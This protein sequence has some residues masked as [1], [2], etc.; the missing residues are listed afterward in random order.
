M[1]SLAPAQR[2]RVDDP[3]VVGALAVFPLIAEDPPAV[4]YLAFAEAVRRGASITELADP[5]V[6]ALVVTNPLDLPVLLYAGQE[7]LG[8]QQNRIVADSVLVLARSERQVAVN[9]VEHGRWDDERRA[10]PF[11]PA[12]QAAYP[13]LRKQAGQAAV[14]SEVRARAARAGV[15]SETEAVHDLYEH[16]R[17][18]LD[19]IVR[20]VAARP[21]QVGAIAAVA[22]A[23]VVLDRVSRPDVWAALHGPL[24][25]G[26]ALQAHETRARETRARETRAPIDPPPAG[27]IALGAIAPSDASA[28]RESSP[29]VADALAFA[30]GGTARA[31][32]HQ[33]ELIALTVYG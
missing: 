33:G 29:L 26:Y 18:E 31:L 21:G 22:G 16:H 11:R 24:V 12:P 32:H 10:E 7:V 20:R 13:A 4:E 2:V 3:D 8:A 14:W 23:F 17:T 6:N 28:E 25:Q 5:S 15:A 1:T 9:C 19:G 30:A 27:R